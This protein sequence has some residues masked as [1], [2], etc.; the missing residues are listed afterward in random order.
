MAEAPAAAAAPADQGSPTADAAVASAPQGVEAAAAAASASLLDSLVLP[1]AGVKRGRSFSGV[2]PGDPKW[3]DSPLAK[4]MATAP[5]GKDWSHTVQLETEHEALRDVINLLHNNK[6]L[7][8]ACVNFLK[9]QIAAPVHGSD[10]FDSPPQSLG[11]LPKSWVATWLA[12]FKVKGLT[13]AW[14]DDM[15]CH[16]P[17]FIT[18]LLSFVTCLPLT[19]TLPQALRTSKALLS[20]FLENRVEH[21]QRFPVV[22]RSIT[23]QPPSYDRFNGG[24]FLLASTRAG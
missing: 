4:R 15:E 5:K 1:G 2:L 7:G 10:S 18:E 16:D 24:A 21:T 20:K 6:H 3:V 17:S 11:R 8:P 14:L 23:D 12:S 22:E 9:R 19:L 13:T